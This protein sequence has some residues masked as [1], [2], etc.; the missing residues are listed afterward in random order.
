MNKFTPKQEFQTVESLVERTNS[1]ETKIILD[2]P[3]QRNVVWNDNNKGA[4]ID[5]VLLGIAPSNIIFNTDTEGRYICIDGKQRLS[6]LKEFKANNVYVESE[7]DNKITRTY[8]SKLP[9]E[10]KKDVIYDE[11]GKEVI[12]TILTQPQKNLFNQMTIPI[13]TYK[14]LS[15]EDQINIFSRIQNGK[16][17]TAGEKFIAFFSTDK[18]SDYFTKFCDKKEPI[19]KK[20]VQDTNRKAH[21]PLVVNIM[22]MI[23]KGVCQIP[24]KNMRDAY[25]KSIDKLP[26]LQNDLSKIDKLIDVCYGANLLGNVLFQND[27]YTNIRHVL[28]FLVYTLFSKKEYKI[29]N[30]LFANLRSAVRKTNRDILGKFSKI[31]AL[32]H[33]KK[34]FIALKDLLHKYYNEVL[35]K[36]GELS[37][38]EEMITKKAIKKID[39]E[40]SDKEESDNQTENNETDNDEEDNESNEDTNSEEESVEKIPVKQ[41]KH[42]IMHNSEPPVILSKNSKQT[43]LFD[44]KSNNKCN[45]SNSKSK[46]K[47]NKH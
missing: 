31:D 37:D 41:S 42:K 22:Y 15:Y 16:V 4:F 21:I 3:Y 45:T 13:I 17:L 25:I 14:E 34:S 5:S 38:E 43:V 18:S 11:K 44:N 36:N 39:E 10:K 2:P 47:I 6:S 8:F 9:E 7:N 35:T 12:Y 23:N 26:K 30:K 40:G 29:N 32:K 19:L 27:L 1:I 20:Y 33:D 24:T 28:V 46:I